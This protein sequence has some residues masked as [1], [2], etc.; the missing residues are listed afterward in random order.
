MIFIDRVNEN[1]LVLNCKDSLLLDE[2]QDYAE[3]FNE[4]LDD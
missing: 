2:L 4:V 1:R 3:S